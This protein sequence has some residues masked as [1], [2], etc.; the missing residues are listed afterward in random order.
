MNGTFIL[1]WLYEMHQAIKYHLDKSVLTS[2]YKRHDEETVSLTL[3][4][5]SFHS[6]S[7]KPADSTVRFRLTQRWSSSPK[8]NVRKFVL[9]AILLHDIN[10]IIVLTYEF[11]IMFNCLI[12]HMC[13][14]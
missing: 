9:H 13:L 14:L 3:R 11:H 10:Y 8:N 1:E 6:S 12:M 2:H 4:N 5:I 7:S